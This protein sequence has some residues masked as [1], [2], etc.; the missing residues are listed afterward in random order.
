MNT[1]LHL[2]ALALCAAAALPLS[3]QAGIVNG[4]FIAGANGLIGWQ[5][6]GDAFRVKPSANTLGLPINAPNSL[7]L[8]TASLL[9]DD[10][11]GQNGAM[12]LSGQSAQDFTA[13]G[14]VADFLGVSPLLL[15]SD[16]VDHTAPLIEGSAAKQTFF[17]QA[18]ETLTFNWNLVSHDQGL[19][20]T[21]W[22]V[23]TEIGNAAQVFQLGTSLD[24]TLGSGNPDLLQT[25]LHQFS[26]TFANSGAMNLAWA[27]ADVSDAGYTTMLMVNNVHVAAAVPEPSGLA[28]VLAACGIFGL[29]VRQ[30]R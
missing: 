20:D 19:P 26:Y 21:A 24:A 9:D 6:T 10:Y 4:Q 23:L 25:G 3:A 22:V 30:K 18:G 11:V 14:G 29:V 2:S 27:V 5:T 28:L 8:T 16:P 15:E 12:N 17:A 1:K 7:V 13:S